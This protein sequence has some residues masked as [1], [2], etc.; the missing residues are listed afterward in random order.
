MLE[1]LFLTIA[2]NEGVPANVLSAICWV[3]SSHRA[4]VINY[5]DGRGDSLGLCQVKL[6][7]ARWMGFKGTREQ[8]IRDPKANATYAA[9][10][11]KYQ[12][13]RYNGDLH[14]AI[15]A[16]NVG[17]YRAGANSRYVQKVLVAVREG[18]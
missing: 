17:H 3:E 16:Y 11:L 1:A 4:H 7:T 2:A 13:K 9:K 10:Y 18:R 8:L 12:L 15:A 14:K 5:A 6:S